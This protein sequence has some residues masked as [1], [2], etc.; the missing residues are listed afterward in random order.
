MTNWTAGKVMTGWMA[1]PAQMCCAAAK[2]MIPP[3]TFSRLQAAWKCVCITGTARGGEA[4][5]DTF[6]GTDVVEYTDSEG[7]LV[8][9]EVPDI[10]NLDGSSFS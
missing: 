3:P 8:T 6:A 5:G 2:A 9:M 10:E 7:N 4:E 1:V